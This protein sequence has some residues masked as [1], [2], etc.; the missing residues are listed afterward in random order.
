[1]GLRERKIRNPIFEKRVKKL[2]LSKKILVYLPF[3][4]GKSLPNKGEV[5]NKN[6]HKVLSWDLTSNQW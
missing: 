1:M 5:P 6:L 4:P 2:T 3:L